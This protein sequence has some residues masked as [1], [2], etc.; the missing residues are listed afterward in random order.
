M[1]AVGQIAA[2]ASDA[3]ATLAEQ[4]GAVDRAPFVSPVTDFYLTNPIARASAVMAECSALARGRLS[5]A[6]E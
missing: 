2:G 6:A 5:V 3:I 4:A 1:A